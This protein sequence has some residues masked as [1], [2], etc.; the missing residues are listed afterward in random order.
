LG[1]VDKKL[2]AE[3]RLRS[4]TFDPLVIADNPEA[5]SRREDRQWHEGPSAAVS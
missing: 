2:F 3:L 4:R 1:G 5:G